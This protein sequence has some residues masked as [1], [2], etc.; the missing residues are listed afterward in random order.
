M[1]SLKGEPHKIVC[2]AGVLF[3]HVMLTLGVLWSWNPPVPV[4]QPLRSHS[5]SQ[6]TQRQTTPNT[7]RRPPGPASSSAGLRVWL[8]GGGPF[9]WEPAFHGCRGPCPSPDLGLQPPTQQPG[10]GGFSG[11]AER[12]RVPWRQKLLSLAHPPRWRCPVPPP[13]GVWPAAPVLRIPGGDPVSLGGRRNEQGA[14]S[15]IGPGFQ[16]AQ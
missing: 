10:D 11:A 16:A 7:Q 5:P 13:P 1:G 14:W 15:H 4:P 2:R 12:T 6:P 9:S 3:A 8:R